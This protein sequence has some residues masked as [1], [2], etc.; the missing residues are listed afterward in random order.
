MNKIAV[1]VSVGILAWFISLP[2]KLPQA[3]L[4][5]YSN[6]RLLEKYVEVGGACEH[7]KCLIVYVAPWC[8]SCKLLT[9]M[10]NKLVSDLSR[11]G[12]KATV[13]IGKDSMNEVLNYSKSYEA[14]ILVD[15]NGY[16][17]DKIGAKGVPYFA[18]ANRE[19]KRISEMSGGY[20]YVNQ[21]RA[22]LEL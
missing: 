6:A 22:Q 15:A 17:F 14:P 1:L 5:R 20:Q 16:Y 3:Q 4:D 8:P 21:M 2:D 7:D 10:I 12:V 19:G 18:V 9:P 11:E 13:V